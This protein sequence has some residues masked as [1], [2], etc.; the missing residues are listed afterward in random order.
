MRRALALAVLLGLWPWPVA[1]AGWGTIEPGV[2][3][4]AQVRQRYGAPTSEKREKVDG[5]DT[6]EWVYEGAQ[7]PAGMVRMAV[8]F[9]LVMPEGYRA[10]IVRVV[11]LAPKPRMFGRL[12]VL[13]GWGRPDAVAKEDGRDVFFYREG[14]IVT[15]D[16]DGAEASSMV[17]APPQPAGTQQRP[18]PSEAPR[19]GA[20]ATPAEPRR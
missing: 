1:A 9:G 4:G 14:L 16:A 7:A 20:P 3:T 17:F 19:P 2:T 6:T 12:T 11:H 18:G 13:E 15:F 8:G 10:D 5:Y